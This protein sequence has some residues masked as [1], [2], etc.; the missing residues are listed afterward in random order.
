MLEALARLRWTETQASC[1]PDRLPVSMVTPLLV[2]LRGICQVRFGSEVRPPAWT[3]PQRP[4][5]PTRATRPPWLVQGIC[6]FG[7]K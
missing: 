4:A 2:H 3:R 5:D 1:P 7:G 6:R